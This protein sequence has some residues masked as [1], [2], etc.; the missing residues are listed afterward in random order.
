MKHFLLS[1]NK[2]MKHGEKKNGNVVHAF[3][4]LIDRISTKSCQRASDR[5]HD[6][7]VCSMLALKNP[8]Y[9]F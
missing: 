1:L 7:R 3:L 4:A 2:Q 8:Y 5:T 6:A 9:Y